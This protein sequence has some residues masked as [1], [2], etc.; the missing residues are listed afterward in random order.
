M[1]M[2]ITVSF[3]VDLVITDALAVAYQEGMH[4]MNSKY[5]TLSNLHEGNSLAKRAKS[6]PEILVGI[7][8][9]NHEIFLD[10]ESR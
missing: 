4:T 2:S 3:Y 9:D 6:K 7:P 1:D 5:P 10:F 8:P